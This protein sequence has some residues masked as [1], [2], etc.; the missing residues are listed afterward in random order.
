MKRV[1]SLVLV[2]MMMI[3]AA[4]AESGES[5]SIFDSIEKGLQQAT[6]SL[7]KE[8]EK[9]ADEA[10]KWAEDTWKE[11]EKWVNGYWG[12][13]SKWVEKT[14][15]ESSSWLS[16]I[17]GDLSTWASDSLDSAGAWW[18]ETFEKVTD[19]SEN[20]WN[21][22]TVA[23]Y[24]ADTDFSDD[25]NNLKDAVTNAGSATLD[26]VKKAYMSLLK[27]MS[28]S[29]EDAGKVWQT[30]MTYADQKGLSQLTT[31]T[32]ALPYLFKLTVDASLSGNKT[33]PPVA[34]AQFLTAALDRLNI[35]S[36]ATA[37]KLLNQLKDLIAS[38]G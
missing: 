27:K 30:I 31:A 11:A 29:D 5:T 20:V 6:D 4:L 24:G 3:P 10:S 23:A 33:M 22:F 16:G 15:N 17:W 21:W 26:S 28:M 8:V 13:A 12:D 9:A 38:F 1:I 7:S 18:K 34:A 36:P 35:D 19:T 37:E 14:W 2:L 32:L 25:Y